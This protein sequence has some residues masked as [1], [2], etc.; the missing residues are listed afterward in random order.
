MTT[1]LSHFRVAEYDHWRRGYEH[2]VAVTP[3]IRT[4]RAWRGQDEESLIVI[5]ET[6]DTR[7]AAQAA[8]TAPEVREMMEADGIDMSSLWVEYFDELAAPE[9]PK[10][11]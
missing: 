4:V 5:E 3:G 11:A 2:A 10:E 1:V 6:F 7:E 9:P 8:W